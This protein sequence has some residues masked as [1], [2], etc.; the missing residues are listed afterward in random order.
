[1]KKQEHKIC[2]LSTVINQMQ[3]FTELITTKRGT[4]SLVDYETASADMKMLSS[5]KLRQIQRNFGHSARAKLGHVQALRPSFVT[6]WMQTPRF[7]R[8]TKK[9][10]YY[11]T[12]FVVLLQWKVKT[13]FLSLTSAVEHKCHPSPL[14]LRSYENALKTRS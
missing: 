1:M 6:N 11:R 2:L 8:I 5:T 10:M 7:K 14:R 3:M 13:L 9:Q 12:N 4:K